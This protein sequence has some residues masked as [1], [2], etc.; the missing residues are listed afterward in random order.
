MS[1]VIFVP[2]LVIGGHIYYEKA[3]CIILVSKFRQNLTTTGICTTPT[4]MFT[5]IL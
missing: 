1:F 3:F 5:P 2:I 4:L